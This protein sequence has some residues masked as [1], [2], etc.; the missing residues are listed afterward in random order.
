MPTT[1]NVISIGQLADIDTIEG[2]NTAENANAL[3]GLTFG[4]EGDALVNDFVE[5]SP[6]GDPGSAYNMDNSPS[7]QFSIDGG[8]AQT[9]DATSVYNAT[10]TYIDGSTATFTAVVMQDVNG[11]TYIAPEFSNNADQAMLEAEAIR[12][13]S[14][15]S[16]LG[17]RYSGTTANRE[18]WDFVPCFTAGTDIVTQKGLCK[19]ED[20]KPGDRVLTMDHGYQVLRWVGLRRVVAR[21]ALAPVQFDVGSIGNDESLR[22]SPQHRMLVTGWRAEM[23]FGEREVLVPAIGMI[24]GDTIRQVEGTHVTYV[25]VMF[26]SHEIIYGAGVPSESFMPGEIGLTALGQNVRDEIFAIFPELKDEGVAAYGSDA[27][28]SLRTG[29]GA[30]LSL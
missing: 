3:V 30:L 20:L 16:L 24:N 17:N 12:S 1:F 25:H 4:S 18:E 14:F 9:F 23:N 6:V 5:L 27:R 10:I 21:G 19:V 29:E 22:V 8:P 7:E 26:D 11:N 2:N 15:D 28:P 13:I